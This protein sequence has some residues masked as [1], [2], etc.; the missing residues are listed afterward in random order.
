ML[1][2]LLLCA[3]RSVAASLYGASSPVLHDL[4]DSNYRTKLKGL[5]LLELY[6]PY[7]P[8]A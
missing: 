5:V 7:V 1:V 6:A 4:T 3:L 8:G 2:S